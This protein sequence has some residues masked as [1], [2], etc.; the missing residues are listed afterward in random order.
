MM[1][2][3][4][5][6]NLAILLSPVATFGDGRATTAPSRPDAADASPPTVAP[7][8]EATEFFERSVRPVLVEQCYSCHSASAGKSKGGLQLDTRAAVAKGGDRGPA[9]VAGDLDKSPLLVAIRW[10]DPEFQMPPKRKLDPKQV[11]ALEQWVRMGAPDPRDEAAAGATA[12]VGDAAGGPKPNKAIDLAAGRK[13]WAFQPLRASDPPAGRSTSGKRDSLHEGWAK[14]KIDRFVLAGLD[15]QHLAPSPEADAR[16]LAQ[17]V[18]LDLTGLRLPYEQVE[19][20]ARDTAPDKYD[21]LVESLLASPR[22]GERWSRHWL[23]VARFGEDNP[24]TEATNPG[25]AYAWRYRDWVI[26]A[27]NADVPYDRFVTLQLAADQVPG[28][29][30]G[31]L[32][33]LGF[34]GAAP[35]YHKDGRLSRDVIETL[36]TDD[37][38]ERV[39]TVTRGVLGLT[40]ACARC[41]DHKFDPVTAADYHAIAGVFASTVAAPRPLAAVDPATETAYM[42]AYQRLFYLSYAANLLRGEPGSKPKEAR[43]RVVRYV[44]EIAKIKSEMRPRLSGQPGMSGQLDRVARLP[45]TYDGKPWPA[46]AQPATRPAVADAGNG[47]VGGGGGGGGGRR[48][49]RGGGFGGE[50]FVNA[51]YDAGLW[52]NPTDGDFTEPDV[53]PGEPRDLPLFAGGNVARPGKPVP[54]RFVEVLAKDSTPFQHGSGRLDLANRMFTDAGPLAARVIVNRVWGWHFGKPLVATPSDFGVQGEKPTHPELLDDLAARFVASGWSLKWLHREVALS[55]TY[56]QASRPR[57]EAV[58]VDPTNKLLWRMNPRRLDIEAFRDSLLQ[59]GGNLDL[60]AGGPGQDLEQ[61]EN[62]RRTVYGRISR[63]RTNPLLMLFDFPEPTLHSPGREATTSPVQQ[64]FVMNSPFVQGQAAALERAVSGD[65]DGSAEPDDAA[66]VAAMYRRALARDPSDAERKRAAEFLAG[67]GTLGQF[68][69]A[70]L[71]GNEVIFWP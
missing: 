69:H 35:V 71:A 4:I 70:L 32:A 14:G 57:D 66:K 33:A 64:L 55:A 58:A 15:A 68:A 22:Y 29:P 18:A 56:R 38:D 37:W 11:E 26:N 67:G 30:R 21:R 24:T 8:R 1:I 49:R 54:R 53:R 23:D 44:D 27:V 16:T 48:G 13:W 6:L 41:H 10:A 9:V 39:D 5:A 40:V 63:G 42:A 36:Y 43:E 31:D 61:G 3:R 28:A 7:S 20:Y 2:R 50:P 65:K 17:R 62:F 59:A 19:A 52:V 12:G 45:D 46:D 25:Y 51:V 34:L 60:T 47:N